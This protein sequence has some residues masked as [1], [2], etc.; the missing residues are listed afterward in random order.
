V[1]LTQSL[2][3]ADVAMTNR[4]AQAAAQEGVAEA[5]FDPD[6][7]TNSWRRVWA[8]SPGW[9]AAWES[10]LASGIENPGANPTVITDG[11]ILAQV[12]SMKPF[13]TI[14]PPP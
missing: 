6:W 1:Y 2:I 9:D 5:G 14:T 10:A 13:T 8:S 4:V 11:E 7:W 12:Q 3:A